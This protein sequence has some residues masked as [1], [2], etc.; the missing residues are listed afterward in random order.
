MNPKATLGLTFIGVMLAGVPLLKLTAEPTKKDVC[1]DALKETP[2]TQTV[3]ARVQFTGTP[4]SCILRYEGEELAAMPQGT[5][6]PWELELHLPGNPSSLELEAEVSWEEGSAE[7]AV[8]ITLEPAQKEA[9]TETRWTGPDGSLLH[10]L[11]IY[12]W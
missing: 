10:D 2:T 9:R 7:N 3:Y 1:V 4:H 12:K 6:S 11:F 8:S 5:P